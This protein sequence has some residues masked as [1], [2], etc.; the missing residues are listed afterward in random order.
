M[1]SIVIILA[2][3]LLL[4]LSYIWSSYQ[5]FWYVNSDFKFSKFIWQILVFVICLC[6]CTF[7]IYK[8]GLLFIDE[9]YECIYG[10]TYP[11]CINHPFLTSLLATIFALLIAFGC[12]CPCFKICPKIIQQQDNKYLF[13]LKNYTLMHCANVEICI[14]G[15]KQINNLL[16]RED[17]D[18]SVHILKMDGILSFKN[19]NASRGVNISNISDFTTI[20]ILIKGTHPISNVTKVFTQSYNPQTD[21]ISESE[22]NSKSDIGNYCSI[23]ADMFLWRKLLCIFLVCTYCIYKFFLPINKDIYMHIFNAELVSLIVNELY[24]KIIN[25]VHPR[26]IYLHTILII[27]TISILITLLILIV[28]LARR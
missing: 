16:K 21:I 20:E 25:R 5:S 23:I 13:S 4:H 24:L 11:I 17:I 19:Q 14:Y 7:I 22:I 26:S 2:L 15:Y 28:I 12:I 9:I 8:G 6:L 1:I 10:I 18:T 27:I 3:L